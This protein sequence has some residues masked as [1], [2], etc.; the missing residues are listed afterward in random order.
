MVCYT[1]Y[2]HILHPGHLVGSKV[3]QM[4]KVA[5]CR[6]SMPG[7]RMVV[8]VIRMFLH[9]QWMTCSDAKLHCT[10][11]WHIKKTYFWGSR[12]LLRAMLKEE[13]WQK[14][15]DNT[16]VVLRIEMC[17]CACACACVCEKETYCS[18][19]T[20]FLS[21]ILS[22]CVPMRLRLS[23]GSRTMSYCGGEDATY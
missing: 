5:W 15:N 7:V 1:V 13:V 14:C 20:L 4:S 11:W 3:L 9:V 19:R 21:L 17:A 6:N 2:R 12:W 16:V 22:E 8:S 10:H 18:G 23:S